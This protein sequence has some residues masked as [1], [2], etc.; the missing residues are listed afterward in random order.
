MLGI[1][2]SIQ[3]LSFGVLKDVVAPHQFGVASG[4]NNMAAIVG[5]GTAQPLIGFVLSHVW[6]GRYAHGVPLYTVHDYQLSL[7]MLPAIAIVGVLVTVFGL[8]ETH[9]R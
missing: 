8:R 7:Y 4:M 5:G 3:S 1:S 9:C 6:D 2:A